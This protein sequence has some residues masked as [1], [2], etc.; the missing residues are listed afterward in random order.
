MTSL[1]PT[2]PRIVTAP[3]RLCQEPM[4]KPLVGRS[5]AFGLG[6]L[7]KSL[8]RPAFWLD[9]ALTIG[10]SSTAATF[11]RHPKL[12]VSLGFQLSLAG[13]N[14]GNKL[15]RSN[16]LWVSVAELHQ[17]RFEEISEYIRTLAP[18]ATIH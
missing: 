2:S 12:V 4:T 7:L 16:D 11:A 1:L 14:I 13:R 15:L 5:A 6:R 8:Q 17:L 9:P 10:I 18:V 3:A